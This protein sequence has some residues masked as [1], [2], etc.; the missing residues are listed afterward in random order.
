MAFSILVS[1]STI[2]PNAVATGRKLLEY[3]D[4][5]C[6]R[7]GHARVQGFAAIGRVKSEAV[8]KCGANA[9]QDAV[10]IKRP[11]DGIGR[12]QRPGLHRSCGQVPSARTNNL[13]MER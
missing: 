4:H 7:G 8:R 12:A 2:S 1:A 5:H 11:R 13:G 6:M 10:G 9:L 3:P